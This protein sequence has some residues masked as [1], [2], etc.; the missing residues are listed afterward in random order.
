MD[1][2][3][4]KNKIIKD[5]GIIA[6]VT[7]V[8]CFA[9]SLK[10]TITEY[11]RLERDYGS[12]YLIDHSLISNIQ[13]YDSVIAEYSK[14]YKDID[15]NKK[16]DVYK[17]QVE[18]YKRRQEEEAKLSEKSIREDGKADN[19]SEEEINKL[20]E[21]AKKIILSDESYV[22]DL[23]Y[24]AKNNFQY[25]LSNNINLE[26]FFKDSSGDIIT[27]IND[28]DIENKINSEEFIKDN[29][30]YYVYFPAEDPSVNK[31]KYSS[32]LEKLYNSLNYSDKETLRFYR[33]PK[34]PVKGDYLYDVW[35]QRDVAVKSL[36]KNGLKSS[37]YA[38]LTLAIVYI[39]YKKRKDSEMTIIEKLYIKVP[40][41]IRVIIFI[42]SIN[43][44]KNLIFNIIPYFSFDEYSVNGIIY[45]IPLIVLDFYLIKDVILILEGRRQLGKIFIFK[46]YKLI[47]N[48][49]KSTNFIKS[50]KFK[51]SFIVIMSI[52]ALISLWVYKN[53]WWYMYEIAAGIFLA[54]YTI[55][56]VI[57]FIVFILDASKLDLKVLEISKGN[58]NNKNESKTVMLKSIENNL[59]TIEDGLKDAIEKAV[60]S[61]KMKS[62]LITNVSHDLKTPLT[63]I[64]NYIDLLK[65][66]VS[67]EKKARYIEVLEMKAKRLK[68][69]I[70]DLFEASKAASGNM[71]FKKEDL[72]ITSLLRQVLGELEEKISKADLNVVTKWPEE[73]VMLYLDGRKTYRVYENLVNNIIKYSMKNS[74]VYIEIINDEN[75]A[76]VVMKNISAYQIDFTTEEIVERFKRGD[77]SRTT[78]GS[79]LG[80]SIAKSIVELQGG[81]FK[82]EI[83]G[84]LFKVS[85]KFKK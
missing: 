14:N 44:I 16:E 9:I 37:V 52:L 50:N 59:I 8:I 75:Y 13:Y 5:L 51:I 19:L 46:I 18:E 20:I 36:Y 23:F 30:Y 41:D 67:D 34:K 2:K 61:E 66:D 63:S 7:L 27:N 49:T 73:K 38:I 47:K 57:I 24:S 1:T 42:H 84:D 85:T 39:L 15:G 25:L 43:S 3:S 32:G 68:V 55:V 62:E 81:E 10:K 4:T 31:E 74:R 35:E 17:K 54:F 71:N 33:F 11:S 26:F 65:E 64:I 6:L 80:L 48:N 82:I 40:I 22:D 70:E 76:T 69:L 45:V 53:S 56:T 78:E 28:N 58:Y 83:D 12:S 60:V 72:N 29:K 77:Q 79:G 21:E